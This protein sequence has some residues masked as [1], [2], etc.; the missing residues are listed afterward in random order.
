M[1]ERLYRVVHIPPAVKDEVSI[2]DEDW[3]RVGT[4]N[5]PEIVQGLRYILDSGE[6]EAIALALELPDTLLI[7]DDRKARKMAN[8]FGL[9]ITGTIGVLIHAWRSGLVPDAEKELE[10]LSQTGFHMTP[11]LRREALRL[12]GQK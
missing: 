1:L 6:S 11:E 8:E 7:T 12:M 3:I 10:R 4:V 5:K 2:I 9:R